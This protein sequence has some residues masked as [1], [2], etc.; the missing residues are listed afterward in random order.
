[1]AQQG[2]AWACLQIPWGLGKRLQDSWFSRPCNCFPSSLFPASKFRS[3]SSRCVWKGS[4]TL[5]LLWLL[6][7]RSSSELP[8]SCWW[9]GAWTQACPLDESSPLGRALPP[10]TPELL[11]DS[12]KSLYQRRCCLS[13]SCPDHPAP[14]PA[15]LCLHLCLDSCSFNGAASAADTDSALLVSTCPPAWAGRA[16]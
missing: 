15:V 2:L 10:R 6:P 11:Q 14:H 3:L 12:H 4:S 9:L 8:T 13:P 7:Q 5:F 1:M 16:G